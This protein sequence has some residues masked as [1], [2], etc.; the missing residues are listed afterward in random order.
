MG[1]INF[2]AFPVQYAYKM[3]GLD[4]AWTIGTSGNVVYQ[5][6]V[7]G[8]YTF[9]LKVRK[10]GSRWSEVIGYPMI[11]RAPIWRH[12]L[13][14]AFIAVVL[15][16]L[17]AMF[18]LRRKNNQLKRRE[19]D[20]HLVALEL[21]SLQSMMNPHFIF[22]ALG[23]IQNFLFQNK[24]GEAGLYLSQFARLIRQNMNAL[25]TAQ[26]SLD[27][28][29]DRLKNYLDLE[30]LRMGN[31]FDY[32]IETADDL[33]PEDVVIPAMIIQ[34]FVENS[35]WHGIASLDEKG[36]ISI[37]FSKQDDRSI[38]VLIIDN[39]IGIS[40]AKA[41]SPNGNKH[42]HLGMEMTRKRLELLG[43]KYA[44]QTLVAY[45]EAFPGDANPGT[46]VELIVP[47]S[48]GPS[49]D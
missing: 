43:R 24:T 18:I 11:I 29:V 22:N 20:H 39:G 25:N 36:F 15:L 45:N 2:S 7:S 6:L 21:K 16:A 33:D 47:L 1:S 46:C 3:E 28:E 30:R 5:R 26:I 34:P 31:K 44:V 49:P 4:T 10:A 12:P 40:R 19:L 48:E 14:F 35:I 23:S 27:E 41:F 37:R 17:V 8:N 38:N 13:F 9:R 42:L 32:R